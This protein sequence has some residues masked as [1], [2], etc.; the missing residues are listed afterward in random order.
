MAGGEEFG[1]AFLKGF[2]M[3][4]REGRCDGLDVGI[5]GGKGGEALADVGNDALPLVA[6]HGLEVVKGRGG[7]LCNDVPHLFC[8][9]RGRGVA[10]G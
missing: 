6:A 8:G 7:G 4:L 9:G 5:E 10:F 3:G 2:A 1:E